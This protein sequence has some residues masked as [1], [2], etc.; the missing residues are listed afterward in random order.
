[1]SFVLSEKDIARFW[2]KVNK[3]GPVHPVLG[4]ACWDYTGAIFKPGKFGA[5]RLK[6]GPNRYT[7]VAAS[8][9]G[10]EI[11]NGR[12]D[13]LFACHKCDRPICVR[14]DHLFAG[15]A[16]DNEQDKIAKGRMEY[17]KGESAHYR[18]LTEAKVLE[19][20]AMRATGMTYRTIEKRLV[21]RGQRL[22]S[23][24]TRRALEPHL[25]W[26]LYCETINRMP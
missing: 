9:I 11:Q 22:L 20:R 26:R 24:I 23:I 18:K 16:R 14:G 15:T 12:L 25:K 6:I 4:T 5:F 10:Y 2:S 8:R 21:S 19:L 13:G 1:M 3:D 17:R 7:Q